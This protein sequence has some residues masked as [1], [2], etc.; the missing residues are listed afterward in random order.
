MYF[1]N[2]KLLRRC[3]TLFVQF[4]EDPIISLHLLDIMTFILK[5]R[6]YLYYD[7]GSKKDLGRRLLTPTLWNQICKIGDYLW[8]SKNPGNLSNSG[9]SNNS[10]YSELSTTFEESEEPSL[11]RP[12]SVLPLAKAYLS[13]QL[14]KRMGSHLQPVEKRVNEQSTKGVENQPIRSEKQRNTETQ[15]D[16]EEALCRL[17]MGQGGKSE[18][19]CMV[20]AISRRQ[21]CSLLSFNQLWNAQSPFLVKKVCF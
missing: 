11:S 12:V 7:Q 5:N 19:D 17:Q 21:F 20:Q 3:L 8:N 1:L 13:P 15:I 4:Y 2:E 6:F 18:L 14:M 10:G 16:G 9:N